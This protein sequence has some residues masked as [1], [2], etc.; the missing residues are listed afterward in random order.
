MAIPWPP[1]S[2]SA[3]LAETLRGESF[4]APLEDL[5]PSCFATWLSEPASVKPAL[6]EATSVK[7]SLEAFIAGVEEEFDQLKQVLDEEALS[8]FRATEYPE[9][10]ANAM[11]A[12]AIPASPF[13]GKNKESS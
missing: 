7:D 9:W 12:E 6:A 13:K 3:L 2:A 8:S 11:T 10:V 5:P 1:L 4:N